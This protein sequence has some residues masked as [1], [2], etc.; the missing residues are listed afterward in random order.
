MF[1]GCQFL[2]LPYGYFSKIDQNQR[3][4]KYKI[5]QTT[6]IC[7]TKLLKETKSTTEIGKQFDS[8]LNL[9]K[10]Q[11][12]VINTDDCQFDRLILQTHIRFY[13]Q[14]DSYLQ[15]GLAEK[16]YG[17]CYKTLFDSDKNP[18]FLISEGLFTINLVKQEYILD[19]EGIE[20]CGKS[21][22]IKNQ[23][24]FIQGV[25]Q[26]PRRERKAAFQSLE[27]DFQPRKRSIIISDESN[28]IIRSKSFDYDNKMLKGIQQVNQIQI[29]YNQ[30]LREQDFNILLR[31]SKEWLTSSLLNSVV[32]YFNWK[33]EI[34]VNQL[35][36][37][38]RLKIPRVLF[39]PS[40][41][42][43]SFGEY[44]DKT[45]YMKKAKGLLQ[46]QLLYYKELNYEMKQVYAKIGFPVN[47]NNAHWVFL[48]FD[49]RKEQILLYDS[50]SST[51][52]KKCRPS[53]LTK[54]IGSFLNLNV[55]ECKIVN[56]VKQRD[57]YSCGYFVSSF[58]EFEYKLQFKQNYKYCYDQNK[59]KTKIRKI[60]KQ[61]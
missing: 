49:L 22:F 61:A 46:T 37:K 28:E 8:I 10:I 16:I 18:R 57:S 51:S 27:E 58:M 13:C 19:G 12:I 21:E 25:F 40:D 55:G 35:P 42:T 26:E 34:K 44:E 33:S 50:L 14:S 11:F 2:Q 43:T 45:T 56:Y 3:E 6:H 31:N 20:Y 48:L 1:R 60:L 32:E 53:A 7:E 9:Y 38:E 23:G 47:V 54:A 4:K 52:I 36:L 24:V 5:N 59:M 17:K 30:Q 29:Q 39:I 15:L 41:V